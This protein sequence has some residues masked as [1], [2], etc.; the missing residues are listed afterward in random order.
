M[1]LSKVS[2]VRQLWQRYSRFTGGDHNSQSKAAGRSLRLS[3]S[4]VEGPI[5]LRL[6][7][8]A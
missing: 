5:A 6:V 4:I 7:Y 2:P 8:N 1:F 3:C